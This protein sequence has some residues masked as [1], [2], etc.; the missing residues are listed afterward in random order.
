MLQGKLKSQEDDFGLQNS[1]LLQELTRIC[2]QLEKM[3][4]ENS[5]LKSK[6][7]T[8]NEGLGQQPE[9]WV[10]EQGFEGNTHTVALPPS[11]GVQLAERALCAR[12]CASEEQTA[13]T[14]E[15]MHTLIADNEALKISMAALEQIQSTQTE[16][17]MILKDQNS[18]LTSEVCQLQEVKNELLVQN[19]ALNMNSQEL[20]RSQN[21][22]QEQKQIRDDQVITLRKDL[23]ESQKELL[24]SQN[25]HQEQKQVLEDQVTAL[26][27]DLE[28]SQK[29]AVK[30]KSML[31]ELAIQA[32]QDKNQYKN[33]LSDVKLQ[34][35]KEILVVR[36][37]Y[38]KE[39]RNL[40]EENGKIAEN[41]HSQLKNEK[42]KTK[43]LESLNETVESLKAQI[44]ALDGSKGWFERRLEEEEELNKS[45]KME[46]ENRVHE[47]EEMQRQTCQHKDEEICAGKEET[48]IVQEKNE[49]LL[50]DMESLKQEMKDM[51]DQQKILEKKGISALKDL[52][53]QLHGER[54]RGDRLQERLQE[55][56]T[57][58]KGRPGLDDLGLADVGS[59]NRAQTGDSSSISSFSYHEIL[60]EQPISNKTDSP[61]SVRPAELSDDEVSDL[62]QRVAEL[63]QEKWNLEEKVKHLEASSSSMAED[64][65]KKRAIIETYVMESKT[66]VG[67]THT[68]S[69]RPTFV[70]VFRDLVKTGDEGVKDMNKKLQ[71]LLEEQLTKNMHLQKD[72]EHLSQELVQLK[73]CGESPHVCLPK[74]L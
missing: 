51:M 9:N 7:E 13:E 62:F 72:M 59:P 55:L 19:E 16:E 36:A 12:C 3:E 53:R 6:R 37:K 60:R 40:H 45:L 57:N 61:L 48:R 24:R 39:L 32:Q 1:T 27:K 49:E 54:K 21:L 70:S 20:H 5:F 4:A 41:L 35:E 17:I 64:I 2:G 10:L 29:V 38:E 18:S 63:Q 22:H 65:C 67:S 71:H 31:D 15:R 30:R 14:N 73:G 46:H 68:H 58:S 47:L 23:E 69:D 56:L 44:T 50:K 33:E 26:W 43:E 8:S 52:K 28:E 25:L 74:S 42:M 66:D 34:H 11:E